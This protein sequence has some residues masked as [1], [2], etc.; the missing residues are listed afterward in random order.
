MFSGEAERLQEDLEL[1]R[2]TILNGPARVFQLFYDGIQAK[3][4][5]LGSCTR[6]VI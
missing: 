5:E 2:P 1:V 6:R 3:I 4:A